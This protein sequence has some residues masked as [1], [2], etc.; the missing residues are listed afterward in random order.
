MLSNVVS[1]I[2]LIDWI[3]R[4]SYMPQLSSIRICSW[5][6]LWF[7]GKAKTRLWLPPLDA[8]VDSMDVDC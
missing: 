2:W 8:A 7:Q 5:Y 3:S 6:V 4:S 1:F